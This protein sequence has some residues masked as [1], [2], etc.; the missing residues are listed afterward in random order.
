MYGH[1]G[2]HVWLNGS[3]VREDRARLSPLDRGFLYGDGLFETLRA[4]AGV[5]FYVEDHL[6]RLKKSCE[7]WNLSSPSSK[8]RLA[9][10]DPNRWQ[11]RIKAVL[12]KNHLEEG[13][14]RVKIVITR[15]VV[16]GLGIPKPSAPTVLIAAFP[17]TAPSPA[18]YERGWR[19]ATFR[20][21]FNPPLS[22]FKTC[23]YLWFMYARQWARDAGF[24][25]ALLTD[26]WGRYAEAT[27]GSLL[28]FL[29]KR[30]IAP[31]T[32]YR[33]RGTAEK[34]IIEMLRKD[35]W[36]VEEKAIR[37]RDLTACDTLWIT[38]SLIGIFP[39]REMDGRA[40]PRLQT[41][42]AARYRQA[43]FREGGRRCRK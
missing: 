17:Y 7:H 31:L 21:G 13:T 37:A 1:Q 29:G 9:L 19:V 34:R 40:L 6:D 38:N 11:R 22:P 30:W 41:D 33:L 5:P 12:Q 25:E 32:R 10:D 42:L 3:L 39:V 36:I 23:N 28:F 26:P 27:T 15:G 35:G 16:D 4:E 20:N 24:D 8:D 18:S 14:A 43:F 2:I